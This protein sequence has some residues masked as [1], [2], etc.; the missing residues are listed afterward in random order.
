MDKDKVA[1]TLSRGGSRKHAI[2]GRGKLGTVCTTCPQHMKQ[3]ESMDRS[4]GSEV[5]AHAVHDM[6]GVPP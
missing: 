5:T 4:Q 6:I 2:E 1:A 3:K